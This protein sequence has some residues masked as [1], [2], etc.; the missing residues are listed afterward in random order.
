MQGLWKGKGIW[1]HKVT[2][3]RTSCAPV[4][5]AVISFSSFWW[6]ISMSS[7]ALLTFSSW[8]EYSMVSI[9]GL[10]E[11]GSERAQNLHRQKG[12]G[13]YRHRLGEKT[14]ERLELVILLCSEYCV[15]LLRYRRSQNR[16]FWFSLGSPFRSFAISVSVLSSVSG[17]WLI[18]RRKMGS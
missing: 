14:M 7:N 18:I 9:F 1:V 15:Y 13:H 6:W 10:H 5:Q 16:S 12:G 8:S 17:E 3:V 11:E 4:R 2:C